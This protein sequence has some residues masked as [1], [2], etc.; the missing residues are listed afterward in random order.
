MTKKTEENKTVRQKI[1][2]SIESVAEMVDLM[3]GQLLF[4]EELYDRKFLVLNSKRQLWMISPRFAISDSEAFLN[5][6]DS[7]YERLCDDDSRG[8]RL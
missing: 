6:L 8:A 7:L 1:A 2:D 4:S 3:G 5:A